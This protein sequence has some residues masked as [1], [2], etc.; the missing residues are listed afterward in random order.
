MSNRDAYGRR[1]WNEEEFKARFQARRIS[2]QQARERAESAPRPADGDLK[3]LVARDSFVE[4]TAGLNRR[5][6]IGEDIPLSRIGH[7]SC[8][9]C[10]LHFKDSSV[11][12]RHLNSPEHNAAIGMSLQPAATT[13]DEV[14]ARVEQW[15]NFYAT[16]CPVPPLYDEA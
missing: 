3:P 13:D 4:L 6:V 14:L 8:P 12:L 9:A 1:T 16:G 7:Y 5:K 10:R 2:E 11:Y 15:E